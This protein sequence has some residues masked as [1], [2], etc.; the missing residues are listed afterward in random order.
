MIKTCLTLIFRIQ[1]TNFYYLSNLNCLTVLP[2][3]FEKL[4]RKAFNTRIDQL[5][6]LRSTET[7]IA[8]REKRNKQLEPVYV[9]SYTFTVFVLQINFL[10]FKVIFYG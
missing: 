8:S 3:S 4:V 1:K 5:M 9:F 10:I 7:Q 2:S 6:H